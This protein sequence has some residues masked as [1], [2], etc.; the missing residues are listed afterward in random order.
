MFYYLSKTALIEKKMYHLLYNMRVFPKGMPRQQGV[1]C[2][3][4]SGA[5]PTEEESLTAF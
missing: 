5:G 2:I 4:D 3:M 1:N